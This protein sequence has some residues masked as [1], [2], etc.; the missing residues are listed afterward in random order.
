MVLQEHD[1]EDLREWTF[2]ATRDDLPDTTNWMQ[3]VAIMQAVIRE[4]TLV[5]ECMWQTVIIN[6]KAKGYFRGIGL[7]K[8]LWTAEASLLNLRIMA[9][10]IYHNALNGFWAGRG[11]V[12]TAFKAKMLQHLTAMREAV[13][14]EVFLDLQKAYN[15]LDR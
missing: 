9:E 7:I 8:F 4:G 2:N 15:A 10:I 12:T 1:S 5:E 11:M 3:V 6:P 13:I 14:F